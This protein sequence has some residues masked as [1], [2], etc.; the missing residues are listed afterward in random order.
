M[1]ND[2][3]IINNHLT[4]EPIV[5][6]ASGDTT[7]SCEVKLLTKD[8]YVPEDIKVTTNVK[9]QVKAGSFN[10][11]AT[12]GVTY[13][14]NTDANT[15]IPA[16]G[17]LYIN[18]GWYP[19]TSISL[20]Q[21][22]PDDANVAN[23]GSDQIRAGYEAYNTDGSQLIGTIADVTVSGTG[24]G[25]TFTHTDT[26]TTAPAVTVATNGTM[27]TSANA[28][29]YGITTTA[30]SG[31]DGTNY[32]SIGT[33][34]SSADGTV[35]CNVTA[36]R[37][38]V[39]QDGD[40]TGYVNQPSTTVLLASASAD[41]NATKTVTT[42]IDSTGVSTYYAPVTTKAAQLNTAATTVTNAVT[43]ASVN[44][45]S[46][47]STTIG[48]YGVIEGTATVPAGAGEKYIKF[49]PA[50]T[51]TTTGNV[52]VTP[53]AT[54]GKGLVTDDTVD[55]TQA[56]IDVDVTTSRS[57]TQYYIPE[58]TR[59]AGLTQGAETKA[60][61]SASV[62]ATKSSSAST[63]ANYGVVETQPTGTG[64]KY[65]SFAPNISGDGGKKVVTPTA[66]TTAGVV[67][68]D[69]DNGT[70]TDVEV[71]ITTSTTGSTY[72]ISEAIHKTSVVEGTHTA[73]T[74]TGK[75]TLGS[76]T[77]ATG[78]LINSTTATTTGSYITLTPGVTSTAG[79]VNVSAKC[80]ST[81]GVTTA[82]DHTSD[83]EGITVTPDTSNGTVYSIKVYK[84]AY[85]I[86]GGATQNA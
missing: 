14:P 15:V 16:N 18:E 23:A 45:T 9:V 2:I 37:A 52:K 1:A 27:K 31:T 62:S 4:T 13:T 66:T 5:I 29:N 50:N 48:E 19:A 57:T 49:A 21:L 8:T 41:S 40:R 73:P 54:S 51:K 80:Q 53:Q 86:D 60:T 61:A 7:Q 17:S 6:A 83:T 39:T 84:G 70:P 3:S 63:L 35:T 77:T 58:A 81:A 43:T 65:I 25:I 30:P 75:L 76:A 67:K 20:G 69:T 11:A 74:A 79:T 44:P 64:V 34:T 46:S 47:T 36:T 42:S 78:T 59:T 33:T 24:G 85:Q 55:G 82:G 71:G 32:F 72:Y 38:D 22:I 26:V 10:N 68:A 56:S 28:G 12:N